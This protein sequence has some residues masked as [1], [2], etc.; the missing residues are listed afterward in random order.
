[1]SQWASWLQ[2]YLDETDVAATQGSISF[3]A[4]FGSRDAKCF[5]LNITDDELHEAREAVTIALFLLDQPRV[6]LDPNVTQV[7]ISNDDGRHTST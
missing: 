7:F 4:G 3:S 5:S 2:L 1:M 6:T